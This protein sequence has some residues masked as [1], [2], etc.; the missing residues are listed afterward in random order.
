MSLGFNQAGTEKVSFYKD[1]DG[2]NIIFDGGVYELLY[3]RKGLT[4]KDA[5]EAIRILEGKA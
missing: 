5:D 2:N 1:D 4:A 3:E